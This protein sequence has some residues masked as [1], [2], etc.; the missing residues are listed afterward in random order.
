[1]KDHYYKNKGFTLV[2]L[3]IVVAVIGILAA[4]AI[5]TYL[6]IQKKA[7]RSEAKAN[8]Q[9]IA[10]VLESYMAEN[11][12]YGGS[13]AYTYWG[14][15]FG[16]SGNV[17]N[18]ANLGSSLEYRY[19]IRAFTA[20]APAYSVIAVPSPT[21]RLAGDITFSLDSNGVQVPARW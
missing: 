1:M 10:L 3:T 17:E 11:N 6:G 4:I 2:E 18:V 15:T 21:G 19:T 12:D 13:P 8:L 9:T 7:A 20:P 16:H 14:G 5:P